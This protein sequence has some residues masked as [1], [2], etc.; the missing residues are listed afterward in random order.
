VSR[1]D[2]V[3]TEYSPALSRLGG[4]STDEMLGLSAFLSSWDI[5]VVTE[6]SAQECRNFFRHAGYGRI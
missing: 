1:T 2:V 6:F 4:L 3:I 5:R